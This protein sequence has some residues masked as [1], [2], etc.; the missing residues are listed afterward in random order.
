MAICR[1]LELTE[2]LFGRWTRRRINIVMLVAWVIALVITV[3]IPTEW[4]ARYVFHHKGTIEGIWSQSVQGYKPVRYQAHFSFESIGLFSNSN[5]MDIEIRIT[6]AN[7]T[8]LVDEYPYVE[9]LDNTGK[10]T[11]TFS[12]PLQ[13][14]PDGEWTAKG[15]MTFY[16]AE[17]IWVFLAP[18]VRADN[19]VVYPS[20][21]NHIRSQ[22][23]M[24]MLGPASDTLS[25][26][27]NSFA[28]K[29]ATILGTFSILLLT[30]MIESILIRDDDKSKADKSQGSTNDKRRI[31]KP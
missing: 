15:T 1:K 25:M 28:V 13:P 3:S 21:Q 19:L 14:S 6:T 8:N 17:R 9:F 5:P 26:K 23:E 20:E 22:G 24:V 27:L 4:Y 12:M 29:V 31:S 18:N 16:E 10:Y 7:V 30:P 2:V 11:K